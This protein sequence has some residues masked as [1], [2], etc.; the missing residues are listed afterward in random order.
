MRRCSNR[1]GG[2]M[3]V[4]A[5]GDNGSAAIPAMVVTEPCIRNGPLKNL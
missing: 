2:S 1:N 4:A 3:A 5:E